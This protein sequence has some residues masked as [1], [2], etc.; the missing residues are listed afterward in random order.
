MS[1]VADMAEAEQWLANWRVKVTDHA[2]RTREMAARVSTIK[3]SAESRDGVVRV[4][5]DSAGTPVDIAL[6]PAVES[7]AAARI[8]AEIMSTMRQ[9]QAELPRRVEEVAATTVGADS[10]TARTLLTP[11][12][13]RFTAH[14]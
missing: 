10:E 1:Y 9:A 13:E 12:Q 6:A 14:E 4:T 8:A 5:V 3:A 2:E 11:Y 7:W